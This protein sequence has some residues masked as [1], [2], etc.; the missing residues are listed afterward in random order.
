[1]LTEEKKSITENLKIEKRKIKRGKSRKIIKKWNSLVIYFN[2][3]D[4]IKCPI[5]LQMTLLN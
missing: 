3:F 2:K 5:Q 1:M 4:Q